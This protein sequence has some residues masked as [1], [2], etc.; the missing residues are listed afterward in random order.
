M[1]VSNVL[2][3][4]DS[5]M[6]PT[7]DMDIDMDID[8]NIDADISALE[9]QTTHIPEQAPAQTNE[10]PAAYGALPAPEKVHVRGLDNLTTD[11]IK[12]FAAEHFPL[13]DFVRVEWVDDTSANLLY[14]SSDVARQ[15]LAALTI[16]DAVDPNSIA[17]EQQRDARPISSHPGVQL[18]IR[19]ATMDDVKR[20]GARDA[21]RFYL[22]NPDKDPR[23]RRRRAME[24]RK[25]G[26]RRL[27]GDQ[28][29]YIRNGFDDREL[30]RRKGDTQNSGFDVSMYDDDAGASNGTPDLTS[31]SRK[32]RRDDEDL[33][34]GK[35][36]GRLRDRSAS[37]VHDGDGRYGFEEDSVAMQRR[38]RRRSHSPPRAQ[39]RSI[40]Q[41]PAS[42]A[43]KELFGGAAPSALKPSGPKELLPAFSASP[44]R[45]K[46]LFPHKT[47]RSNHRRTDAFDAADDTS[48]AR[49]V[50]SRSLADRITG[51]PASIA[52]DQG[53]SIRGG[54]REPQP[55]GFS[56]RGAAV[57]GE[58]HSKVKELFPMKAGVGG[59]GNET[60]ELFGE[61]IKGRGGRRKAEDMFF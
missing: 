2:P 45:S 17:P 7:Y 60:K 3:A 38:V 30:R 34:A 19:Q 10:P 37:P 27:S 21:S 28:G 54:A 25:Q 59:T 55:A 36:V 20:R 24:E 46:D 15:A 5:T 56:I 57:G 42:N 40:A 29:D 14:R 61:K 18:T 12:A 58:V 23:E 35:Q 31:G 39:P 4:T 6:A 47:E 9:H 51:G 8:L 48:P 26:G 13:D 50:S 33:F 49:P 32:R 41:G 1:E 22:L 52:G 11:D 53:F 16:A 43:G 44:K